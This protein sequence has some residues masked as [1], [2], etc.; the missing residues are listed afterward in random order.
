[1]PEIDLATV[2]AVFGARLRHAGLPAGP[3]RSERFAAAIAVARPDTVAELRWCAR[4]TLATDLAQRQLV[5]RVF[6][7]VFAGYQ[8]VTDA[9]RGDPNAPP[10]TAPAPDSRGD[11]RPASADVGSAI[12]QRRRARLRRSAG[13]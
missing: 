2:V 8:D 13:A 9:E 10:L 3:D 4:A 5:D 1:M 7:E 11:R 6:D 12:D